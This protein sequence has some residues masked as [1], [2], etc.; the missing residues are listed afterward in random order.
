MSTS[1]QGP[2]P[3]LERPEPSPIPGEKDAPYADEDQPDDEHESPR[4]VHGGEPS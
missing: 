3:D 4:R 1:P 2:D